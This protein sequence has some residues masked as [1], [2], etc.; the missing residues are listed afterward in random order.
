MNNTDWLITLR[1]GDMVLVSAS[2]RENIHKHISSGDP[3]KLLAVSPEKSIN[4]V[5]ITGEHRGLE[6]DKF[7]RLKNKYRCRHNSIHRDEEE[8]DCDTVLRLSDVHKLFGTEKGE[9]EDI[10]P[11]TLLERET[12]HAQFTDEQRKANL[13]KLADLKNEIRAKHFGYVKNYDTGEYTAIRE[14]AKLP[15]LT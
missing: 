3:E 14:G 11:Q 10:T 9:M 1:S 6:I 13:H 8:C 5:E 7:L 12:T 15:T 2:V 4:V